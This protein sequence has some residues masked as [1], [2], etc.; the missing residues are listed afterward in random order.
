VDINKIG[1]IIFVGVSIGFQIKVDAPTHIEN[2]LTKA[3]GCMCQHTE[4]A[5]S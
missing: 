4:K 1:S 2:S 3:L 5:C